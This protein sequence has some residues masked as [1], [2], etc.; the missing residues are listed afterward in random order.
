MAGPPNGR[1]VSFLLSGRLSHINESFAIENGK[2]AERLGRKAAGLLPLMGNG[3]RATE[4]RDYEGESQ[5]EPN[6]INPKPGPNL[7]NVGAY[8]RHDPSPGGLGLCRARQN[9]SDR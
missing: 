1:R 6:T 5:N 4:L 8:R 2:P 7:A 3:S 9:S